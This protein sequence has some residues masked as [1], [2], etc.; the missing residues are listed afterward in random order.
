MTKIG[1]ML[2][3]WLPAGV[4]FAAVW[5]YLRPAAP[6]LISTSKMLGDSPPIYTTA[7]QQA[8]EAY[9]HIHLFVAYLLLAT[10]AFVVGIAMVVV[11][12]VRSR[13][14]HVHVTPT[15]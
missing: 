1:V 5:S 2:L 6:V 10:L 9:P 14:T 3:L 7:W 15:I 4:A 13:R 11:G 12:F 8:E